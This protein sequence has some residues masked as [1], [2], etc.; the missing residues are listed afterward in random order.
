M[1]STKRFDAEYYRR[2]YVNSRTAVVEAAS[3]RREVAFV[4]AFCRHIGLDVKRFSDVGAGTGWW[5]KEF[6][7]Q[8][9]E[10]K[11]IET[12]DASRAA[13]DL[14]G[15]GHAAI[16]DL[17]GRESDLV[18]CRDVLRYIADAHLDRAIR[19]LAKKCRGV[20]YLHVITREDD[21]DEDAS[22]MEG[23]FRTTASY[24]RRLKA[25]GFRD[26][27]MGLFVSKKLKEFQPF[28]L[29]VR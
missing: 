5:A 13:C 1:T 21:I 25:A 15:H 18:V 22:D 7:R 14:Y 17:S 19:R 23:F 9:P 4:I 12:F 24:R 29:E 28:T 26:C 27:G 10:C 11:R 20:L 16:Q 2:Y 3:Q 8:Y 6:A